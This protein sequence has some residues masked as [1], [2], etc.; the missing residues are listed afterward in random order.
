MGRDYRRVKLK[1][2]YF[3]WENWGISAGSDAG[4]GRVR[5]PAERLAPDQGI[6]AR[7]EIAGPAPTACP[8]RAGYQWDVDYDRFSPEV[9][10]RV[11]SLETDLWLPRPLGEVFAFFA[12]AHNLDRLTPPW[13][14]FHILTPPGLTMRRG[15]LLDYRLRWHG[16]PL[17]WKTEITAW[18][19]PHRFVDEQ[20]KGPYPL[21]VHEHTFAERDGGTVIH[22]HVR[23]AIPGGPLE[24]L[25]HRLFVGPDLTRIF[26][27]RQART[28]ELLTGAS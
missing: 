1:L 27:Y 14:R 28:R 12:D 21:W 23:Y 5:R 4:F 16:L 2:R 9:P 18:E 11:R 20:K 3:F 26:A 24:P 15:A 7:R 6:A 13:L 19:P 8:C 22:D 10:V 25:L 17:K